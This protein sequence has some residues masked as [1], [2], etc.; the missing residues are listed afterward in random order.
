MNDQLAALKLFR[1][2][3]AT[4]SFSQAAREQSLTQ[5]TVSRIIAALEATLGATLFV[6]TTRAVTLTETGADYLARITPI[7]EDLEAADDAARGDGELRGTLHIGVSSIMASRVLV[8]L[9][10]GFLGPHPLLRIELVIDDRRQDLIAENVDVAI[11]FGALPDSSAIARHIGRWPLVIAAAPSYIAKNGKPGSPED[12]D[13]HRFI[14]AG[15]AAKKG[16]TFR[17][18]DQEV[19]VPV[20]GTLAIT[21]AEVAVNAGASG[22]GIVAA[23]YP[24][25]AREI[26]N[27]SLVRL[28]PDWDLG[29]LEAH[30]LFPSGQ[31]PRPSARAF[32]EFLIDHIRPR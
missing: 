25:V 28:L 24:S 27:G 10:G 19:A 17:Q 16:L 18:G 3:A 15:P 6:R 29:D 30:A 4:G 23:S 32:V 22:L 26:E 1:R 21:G 9:L 14:I 5:P 31:S 11:R 8:P 13:R 20:D 7:L 2:V 12:L